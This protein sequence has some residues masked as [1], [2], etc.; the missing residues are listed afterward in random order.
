MFEERTLNEPV[1][2]FPND[3]RG[4]AIWFRFGSIRARLTLVAS[5]LLKTTIE[6]FLKFQSH[7]WQ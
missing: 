3:T 5:A 4:L 1:D 2:N 6:S 7:W